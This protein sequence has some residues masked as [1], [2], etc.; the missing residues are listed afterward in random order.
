MADAVLSVSVVLLIHGRRS[1]TS[2]T[3][4]LIKPLVQNL[5]F[6][7]FVQQCDPL[8]HLGTRLSNESALKLT[9]GR[10]VGATA[11]GARREIGGD[12]EVD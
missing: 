5:R 10:T 8:S 2:V 3:C 4:T 6:S 9:I 11:G 12:E 1:P 7:S